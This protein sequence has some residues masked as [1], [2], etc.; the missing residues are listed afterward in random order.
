M[1]NV[2]AGPHSLAAVNWPRDPAGRRMTRI[3]VGCTRAADGALADYYQ[4]I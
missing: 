3:E 2:V 4:H 1:H